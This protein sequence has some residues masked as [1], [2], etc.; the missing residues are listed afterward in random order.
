MPTQHHVQI[1]KE[2]EA[3]TSSGPY[4]NYLFIKNPDEHVFHAF[5]H[6][7]KHSFIQKKSNRPPTER[8][9]CTELVKKIL[10]LV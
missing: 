2:R 9:F 7:E 4:P 10:Q 1:Q 5:I 3:P 6:Q 8:K